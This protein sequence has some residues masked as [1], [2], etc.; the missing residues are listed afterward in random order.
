[1]YT[2]STDI[3]SLAETSTVD[4]ER[5][6]ETSTIGEKRKSEKILVIIEFRI[7]V[8]SCHG[9]L[10]VF[11]SNIVTFNFKTENELQS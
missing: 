6:L 10:N 7:T 1:M 3:P 11:T 9:R 5:S 2:H 8:L 4:R